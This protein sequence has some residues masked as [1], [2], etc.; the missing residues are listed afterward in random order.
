LP[1]A[2]NICLSYISPYHGGETII[3]LEF[4]YRLICAAGASDHS[5]EPPQN[6]N[7]TTI[8]FSPFSWEFL[9]SCDW[10]GALSE[11]IHLSKPKKRKLDTF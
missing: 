1:K 3:S 7:K 5:S 4:F 11:L 6:P 10:D 9:H 8:F 2:Q